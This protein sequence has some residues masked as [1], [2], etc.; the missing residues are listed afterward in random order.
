MRGRAFRAVAAL[1]AFALLALLA[2]LWSLDVPLSEDTGA[3]LY[4]GDTIRHGGVPYLD[5]ADN[6]GPATYLLFALLDPLTGGSTTALRLTLV[7]ACGLAALAVAARVR[8]SAGDWA[9][10][11][12]GVLVAV[13]G[14]TP[15][16]E[17][18]D[19]NTEQYG[20]LPLAVAWW[21]AARGGLRS[22]AAAGAALAAAVLMNVGFVAFAP[23]IALE[24]WFGAGEARAR[25]FA[26]ATGAAVA[27]VALPLLWLLLSGAFDDMWTQVIDKAQN[28]VGGDAGASG[29]FGD[30]PLFDIPTKVP[31]LLGAAGA[32][33]ALA[34][35]PLRVA[36]AAALLWVLI[37]WLRVKLPSYEFAH[38]YYVAVPGVGAGMAL[39]AAAV[40][41]LLGEHPRLRA[42]TL[43]GAVAIA[44]WVAWRYVA[45]PVRREYDVPPAQ[46]VRFP[47][48]ALAYPVGDALRARTRPD[49][50]VMVSGNN[51]TVY[52]R[53]DRRAPNRFFAEY[54]LVPRYAR[55]RHRELRADPPDAIVLMPERSLFGG[56]L[57]RLA[58]GGSY[59]RA[60]SRD[61]ASIWLRG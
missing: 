21:L 61:G 50:T 10:L 18:E 11:G 17:G 6:K 60:W 23:V 16:L 55:E 48:Y 35:R 27:V 34:R 29:G 22:A 58:H 37:G 31:F 8:R 51:P 43:A 40:V 30:R 15:F 7:L 59:R 41:A 54:A 45:D 4:V 19:L 24:L 1:A 38:H 52:W 25:R 32:A 39:G 12:A 42:A 13:F 26:A 28:A 3:Y 56:E 47:Q 36:G 33:V 46:R 53:A 2:R 20:V 14:S 44:G 5:A 9:G 49:D 57:R